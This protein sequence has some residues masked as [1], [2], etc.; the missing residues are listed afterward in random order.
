LRSAWIVATSMIQP[1][2]TGI[3]TFQPSAMN[4]S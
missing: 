3:R 1:I 4:W 2:E